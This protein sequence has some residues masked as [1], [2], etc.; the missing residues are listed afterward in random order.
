MKL[1]NLAI[2]SMLAIAGNAHA[3]GFKCQT[4]DG[5]LA[6][7]IFNSVNPNV[8]TRVGAVMVL[9]DPSV[10]GGRKTIARFTDANGV[11]SS[12]SSRY[13]ANVDLRFSDSARKGENIM[14]T[15]L[16][17]LDH[18]IVDIDFSYAAPVGAGEE[19][20]GTIVLDKRNGEKSE[21]D[22]ICTRYLKGE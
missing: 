20:T 12:R 4:V 15:K 13:D 17:E 6:V 5:E 9:S 14:G 16:G 21:A 8:G 1:F 7:K 22:L 2:V 19:V 3:D 11:L 10:N 18:V